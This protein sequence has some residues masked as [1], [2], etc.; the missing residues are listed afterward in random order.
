[1]L[2]SKARPSDDSGSSRSDMYPSSLSESDEEDQRL[3]ELAYMNGCLP[4]SRSTM[5]VTRENFEL[6][7]DQSRL[8]FCCAFSVKVSKYKYRMSVSH[9]VGGFFLDVMLKS[10]KCWALQN[11]GLCLSINPKTVPF[12]DCWGNHSF[13]DRFVPDVCI[14]FYFSLH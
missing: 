6:F 3:I 11:V 5:S 8:Y 1:M 7:F 13:I 9:A 10:F 4:R 12:Y 14:S 2:L